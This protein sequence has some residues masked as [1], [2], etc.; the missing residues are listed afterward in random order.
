MWSLFDRAF[1]LRHRTEGMPGEKAWDPHFVPPH[2]RSFAHLVLLAPRLISS[3]TWARNYTS[4]VGHRES[5]EHSKNATTRAEQLLR[6]PSVQTKR[7]D[8]LSPIIFQSWYDLFL[9]P[10]LHQQLHIVFSEAFF[11]DPQR[12]LRELLAFLELP[13]TAFNV[14]Y[15]KNHHDARGVRATDQNR[16]ASSMAT[17]TACLNETKW[18]LARAYA[19]MRPS[20]RSTAELLKPLGYSLPASWSSPPAACEAAQ[21]SASGAAA[22]RAAAGS[23]FGSDRRS[24]QPHLKRLPRRV[25][26]CR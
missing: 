19:L 24:A 3:F 22:A 14:S 1:D 7:T 13:T 21:R 15:I 12:T 25:G 18:V 11:D 10:W 20:I 16:V 6:C 8:C 2:V 5:S 9:P 17:A 23:E 4:W 26:K